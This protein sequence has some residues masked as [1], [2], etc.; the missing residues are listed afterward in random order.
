MTASKV[1]QPAVAIIGADIDATTLLQIAGWHFTAEDA[2]SERPILVS[3]HSAVVMVVEKRA[4][5]R[6]TKVHRGNVM[7]FTAFRITSNR[8]GGEVAVSN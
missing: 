2:T 3:E 5:L 7:S 6:C 8:W 4:L 1:L